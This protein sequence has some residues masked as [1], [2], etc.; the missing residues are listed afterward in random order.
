MFC[1]F[2][3]FRLLLFILERGFPP[4]PHLIYFH[5]ISY[6]DDGS[7][8]ADISYHT[9]ENSFQPASNP[10]D[11]HDLFSRPHDDEGGNNSHDNNNN[12]NDAAVSKYPFSPSK[13]F[14]S[15]SSSFKKSKLIKEMIVDSVPYFQDDKLTTREVKLESFRYIDG[16]ELELYLAQKGTLHRLN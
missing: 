13:S 16:V 10:Q 1:L 4:S 11:Q 2:Y 12:F 9:N 14:A 6:T 7:S 8:I 3:L 15:S 5:T